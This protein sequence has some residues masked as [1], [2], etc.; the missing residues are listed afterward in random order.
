[1][2]PA[3]TDWIENTLWALSN[4]ILL[5]QNFSVKKTTEKFGLVALDQ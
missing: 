1:M 2:D 5:L 4:P 3:E